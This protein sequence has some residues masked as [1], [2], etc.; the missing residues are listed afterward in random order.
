MKTRIITLMMKYLEVIMNTLYNHW[1]M[2]ADQS[3]M[4]QQQT[5]GVAGL[6]TDFQLNFR[7]SK[8][9]CWP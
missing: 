9:M 3:E 8:C 2:D 6:D 4:T 5:P 1:C 7:S